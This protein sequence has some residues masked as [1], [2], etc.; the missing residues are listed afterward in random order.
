MPAHSRT[1]KKSTDPRRAMNIDFDEKRWKAVEDAHRD[2]WSGKSA[3]PLIHLTAGG[4]DPGRP[5]PAL[6]LHGFA[7]FYDDSVSPEQIVDRWL[8][9]IEG[10][11]FLGDSFPWV[12]PNFGPGVIAAFMG[13]ELVNGDGTVWFNPPQ[14]NEPGEI[15]MAYDP[16][17]RWFR[18]LCDVY[19]AAADRFGTLVQLAMTDLGGNL[20]IVATF[21]ESGNLAMDLYDAPEDVERLVWKAHEMWWKYFAEIS[22]LIQR[23]HRGYSAWTPFYSETPYYILQCDFSFMI[24]TDAFRQFALPEIVTSCR[25]LSNPFFHLDGPG[26]LKHLDALL[27]I[28]E[29]KGIQWVPGAGQPPVTEWP[30]V[31]RKIRAAGKRIQFFTDQDPLGWR[32]L[33]VLADQLGD[34]SGIMMYGSVPPEEIADARA[35]IARFGAGS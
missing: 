14:R 34:T 31:Y 24:G 21:R 13:L 9:D 29:L 22:A 20:D 8:Y 6:P 10:R 12:L 33:E 15:T 17:N 16:C 2:W 11:W 32:S 4:R 23:G 19:R 26:A 35:M 5:E 28:P 1:R 18:R 25:R 30:E 7:S 3:K 27:E